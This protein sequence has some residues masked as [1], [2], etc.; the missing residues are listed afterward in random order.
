METLEDL[1]KINTE[2]MKLKDLKEL[3]RKMKGLIK[4][5]DKKEEVLSSK[6]EDLKYE[7]VSVVGKKFIKLKFDLDSKEAVVV[8]SIKDSRDVFNNAM[9]FYSAKELLHKL[10]TDTQ[11]EED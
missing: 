8:D 6:S 11:Q 9:A 3:C 5:R 10:A 2:T 4:V 7:A 1:L